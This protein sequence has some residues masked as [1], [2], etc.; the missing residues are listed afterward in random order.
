MVQG[1]ISRGW[2]GFELSNT[3]Y[4]SKNN[5]LG[6]H[7]SSAEPVEPA[8]PDEHVDQVSWTASRD[9]PTTR[10]GGQDDVIK[11]T[12]SNYPNSDHITPTSLWEGGL[13]KREGER[14]LGLDIVLEVV[15]SLPLTLN[16]D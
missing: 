12:P 11:H 14:D 4:G 8:E 3:A 15:L 6:I 13:C 9:H 2:E 10:A 5:L 7:F 16:V 1:H